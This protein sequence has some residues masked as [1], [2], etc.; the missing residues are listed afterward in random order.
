MLNI[1][2]TEFFIPLLF[3]SIPAAPSEVSNV[4]VD[5]GSDTVSWLPPTDPGGEIAEYNVRISQNGTDVRIVDV[6]GTM[7]SLDL[8]TLDIE[9][10]IY[11][12]EVH[13]CMNVFVI[14]SPLCV[15]KC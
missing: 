4:I 15:V 3:L 6:P 11:Q 1:Y 5:I 2:S 12:L 9:P 10:G 13:L 8:S 14:A 7:T